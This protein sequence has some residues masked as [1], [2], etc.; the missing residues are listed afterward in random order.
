M[1]TFELPLTKHTVAFHLKGN[2]DA[3]EFCNIPPYLNLLIAASY[4]LQKGPV[5]VCVGGLH[6]FSLEKD[7]RVLQELQVIE[8]N[9]T[10]DI[11]WRGSILGLL[12]YLGQASA[13]VVVLQEKE[14]VSVSLSMCLSLDW[15]HT[16]SKNQIALSHSDG[17]ISV[18]DVGQAKTVVLLSAEVHEFETWTT[19]Y[20]CWDP[21]VGGV[22]WR[23][24]WHP[25]DQGLILAACMHN[26]FMGESDNGAAHQATDIGTM[27]SLVATCFF[28]DKALHVWEPAT[29]VCNKRK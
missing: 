7:N 24:K 6:V 21:E 5:P 17:L 28:Y 13:D 15:C 1:C 26:G 8:T 29:Q 27:R 12:P 4:T 22:V 9:G 23:L 20:D 2:A 11:K 3:V 10:F 16:G 25:F 14:Y 18:V 19:S